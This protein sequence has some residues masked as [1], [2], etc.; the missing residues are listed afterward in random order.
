MMIV[1]MGKNE[2]LIYFHRA[3]VGGKKMAEPLIIC[4]QSRLISQLDDG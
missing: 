4:A 2:K 3:E 1:V